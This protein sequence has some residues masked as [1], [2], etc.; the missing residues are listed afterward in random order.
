MTEEQAKSKWC[1]FVRLSAPVDSEAAGTAGNRYGDD[2]GGNFRCIASACMAWR[3]KNQEFD[4]DVEL[5]SRTKNERVNSAWTDDAEWRPVGGGG[6]SEPPTGS[7]YC[8]LAGQ[9]S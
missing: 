3:W 2:I 8:G 7:G 6:E 5:W 1:P 9:P 4:R